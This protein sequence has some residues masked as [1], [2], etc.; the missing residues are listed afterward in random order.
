M[1]KFR[2]NAAR[3]GARSTLDAIERAILDVEHAPASALA[4]ILGQ[5]A[6]H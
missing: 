6:H 3:H 5:P 1:D 4:A 2:S